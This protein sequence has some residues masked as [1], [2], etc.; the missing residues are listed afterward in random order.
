M[1]SDSRHKSDDGLEYLFHPACRFFP[2]S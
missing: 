1:M 2:S